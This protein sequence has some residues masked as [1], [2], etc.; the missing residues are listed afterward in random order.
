MPHKQD[1][2]EKPIPDP[3]SGD[4]P[5]GPGDA[6]ATDKP[7]LNKGSPGTEQMKT[8]RLVWVLAAT[9]AI[10]LLAYVLL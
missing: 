5:A 2:M 4:V 3:E 8:S 1:N 9:L 10:A 6:G 7:R